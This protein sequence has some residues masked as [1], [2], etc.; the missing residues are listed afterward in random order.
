MR[1]IWRI[2][3][4][5]AVLVTMALPTAPVLALTQYEH[6]T[7][8][9]TGS[10]AAYGVN[11][12]DGQTFTAESDHTI[13]SI[14][15]K[16]YRKGSPGTV[17]L[18]LCGTT[19]GHPNGYDIKRT[20]S[21]NGNT[22]TNNSAGEWVTIS[23]ASYT[24]TSGTK[25]G[26][27]L[28]AS[29]GDIDNCIYWLYDADSPTYTGGNFEYTTDGGANWTSYTSADYMFDIY[30]ENLIDPPTV[31]TQDASAVTATTATGNGNI[32]DTGGENCT[33]RGVVYDTTSQADPDDAAPT[34]SGYDYYEESTGSFSTGAFTEALTGLVH[35][36]TYYLR[37]YAYNSNGYDYGEEVSFTTSI[38]TPAINAVAASNIAKTSARLNSLVI[39][40]GGEECE[41]RFGWDDETHAG[42]FEAYDDDPSGD[43]SDWVDGYTDAEQ[44]YLDISS[45][46]ANTQYFFSV[47]IKNSD[48]TVTCATELDFTTAAAVSAPTQFMAIPEATAI[49]LSWIK[50]DGATGTQIRYKYDA[51]PADETEG[52]L[53]YEGTGI[54]TT[55]E[56]LDAGTVVYFVAIGYDGVDYSATTE[57][58]A[59]TL[60]PS[61]EDDIIDAPSMPLAWLINTDYTTMSNFEPFYTS[62]NNIADEAGIPKSSFWLFLAIFMCVFFAFTAVLA[63]HGNWL[64]GGATLVVMMAIATTQSL[65][66]LFLMLLS[67]VAVV[68]LGLARRNV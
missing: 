11:L 56:G 66:P 55:M 13:T 48:S 14:K 17:Y 47:Q 1:A 43:I 61:G 16:V 41:V 7:T 24:V 51:Y 35:G 12:L 64:V 44:P 19:G 29:S 15:I 49:N 34:A 67:V 21:F 2:L 59:S 63:S 60:A 45:L 27:V 10:F 32:T 9:E 8:G 5:V 39:D 20:G 53:L 62:V 6:Y 42:D 28:K 58:M 40:D 50:G 30:G 22:I 54:S 68:G 57:L 46:S 18:Y 26:L 23:V 37:A 3:V 36:T 38:T 65:I 25:Y 33:K 4:M 52:T 31:T